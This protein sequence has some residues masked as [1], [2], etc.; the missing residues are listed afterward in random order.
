MQNILKTNNQVILG[1]ASLQQSS[2]Q[3]ISAKKCFTY[4]ETVSATS[5][6]N[7]I[8]CFEFRVL[9]WTA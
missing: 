1:F 3:N 7:L 8:M 4:N 2:E 6:M 9:L 5:Y